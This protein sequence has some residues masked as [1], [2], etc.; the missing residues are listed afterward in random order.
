MFSTKTCEVGEKGFLKFLA[1]FVVKKPIFVK[2]WL[3]FLIQGDNWNYL[4]LGT[5]FDIT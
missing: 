5:I 2:N 4:S 3:S 1:I